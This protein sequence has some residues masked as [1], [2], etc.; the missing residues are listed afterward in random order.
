ML[1]FSDDE[2]VEPVKSSLAKQ[3]HILH[4]DGGDLEF[5][6]V[7]NGTAFVHLVGACQGCAA[8][9]TTLK[10]ALERQLKIDIHPEITLVNLSGGRAEFENLS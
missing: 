2:L 5:L 3:L 9:G 8:S 6:G 1:P 7:K 10:Y 4:Q